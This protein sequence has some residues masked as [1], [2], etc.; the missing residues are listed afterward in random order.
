MQFRSFGY[1]CLF[2]LFAGGTVSAGELSAVLWR[3]SDYSGFRPSHDLRAALAEEQRQIAWERSLDNLPPV[4]RTPVPPS[5]AG[6]GKP[7]AHLSGA[8]KNKP[9]KELAK[10]PRLDANGKPLR[11]HRKLPYD[12]APAPIDIIVIPSGS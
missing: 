12:T 3:Q 11:V 7:S 5:D 10:G 4:A 9:G 2:V 1:S 6:P 8:S